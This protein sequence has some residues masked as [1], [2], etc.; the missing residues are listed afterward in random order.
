MSPLVRTLRLA[1]KLALAPLATA[2]T[3]ATAPEER[4]PA[5]IVFLSTV[6]T[7][8]VGGTAQ[9]TVATLNDNGVAVSDFTVQWESLSPGVATVSSTGLVTGVTS[10]T[11]QIRVRSGDK[12]ATTPVTVT[13]AACSAASISTGYIVNQSVALTFGAGDCQLLNSYPA[14]GR[15]LDLSAPLTLRLQLRSTQHDALLLITDAALNVVDGA[16]AN[17]GSTATVAVTLPA[18]THYIWAATFSERATGSFTLSSSP[19]TRC[20]S[21]VTSGA[22]VVGQTAN[23][24]VTDTSCLLP[25]DLGAEGWAFSVTDSTTLRF[26]AVGSGMVPYL[27]ATGTG[28]DLPLIAYGT[29]MGPT[30]NALLHTF[31]PGEYRIWVSSFTGTTGSYT[32][33]MA[34][35]TREACDAV[36][37]P[38]AIGDTI[39]GTLSFDD[40]YLETSQHADVYE[41][42]V[43]TPTTV[44]IDHR[45]TDFDA[46]LY[47]Q[48]PADSLIAYDDD[49]GGNLNSRI[50]IALP[51]GVYRIIASGYWGDDL[52]DYALSVG[53]LSSSVQ[54]HAAVQDAGLTLKRLPRTSWEATRP[55]RPD[56]R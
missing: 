12:V 18:G 5:A 52:G 22:I 38:I 34:L 23:G 42:T 40:C 16:S 6:S 36:D 51:A 15:R 53:A 43:A 30:S 48:T 33:S 13:R 4:N 1:L 26:N 47:L 28:E 44:R 50:E 32:L 54:G 24:N 19:F 39:R 2:C 29:R 14:V 46:Y 56:R 45:S 27:Y 7:I 9:L 8:S 37:A 25:N 21:A 55:E 10:G 17:A 3:E 31:P 11:A 35:G 20:V 41:L 49:A